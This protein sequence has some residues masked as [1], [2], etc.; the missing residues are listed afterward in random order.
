MRK[1]QNK[2][3]YNANYRNESEEE[4][5]RFILFPEKGEGFLMEDWMSKMVRGKQLWLTE[6]ANPNRVKSVSPG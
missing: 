5:I 6:I 4:T 2:R 3:T 1:K